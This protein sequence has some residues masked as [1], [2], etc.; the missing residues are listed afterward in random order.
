MKIQTQIR[1]M[2]NVSFGQNVV[3]AETNCLSSIDLTIPV[4]CNKD[5]VTIELNRKDLIEFLLRT[6]PEVEVGPMRISA[7]ERTVDT[8]K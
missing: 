1:I 5:I 4:P 7:F 3:K 6:Q 2:N 8:N